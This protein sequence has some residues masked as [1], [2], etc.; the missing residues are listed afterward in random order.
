MNR[1]AFKTVAATLVMLVAFCGESKAQFFENLLNSFNE[2]S[3]TTTTTVTKTISITNANLA[4]V[5]KYSEPSVSISGEGAFSEAIS[6]LAAAQLKT[7]IS[8]MC[9]QNGITTGLFTFTFKSNGTFSCMV[10]TTELSG[11]Y[12]TDSDAATVTLSFNAVN[13][14][15]IDTMVGD[16]VLDSSS[17]TI[18]FESNAVLSLIEK[19]STSSNSET[20]QGISALLSAYE[21]L[22]LGF[23]MSK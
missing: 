13:S 10:K 2:T 11:S 19:F 17:L 1:K 6:A 5:W 9:A 14:I 21:G 3:S 12:K 20:I 16:A 23:V 22:R 18:L 7:T 4:G 15:S 8:D